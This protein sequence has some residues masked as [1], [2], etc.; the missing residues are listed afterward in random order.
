MIKKLILAM[1]LI[2]PFSMA[3][4]QE[5]NT[6]IYVLNIGK[7]DVSSG[8]YTV[9]FYLTMKCVSNCSE[10]SEF[11]NGRAT[12][13][14]KQYDDGTEKSYR[15]QASLSQNIYMRSYPFDSHRLSI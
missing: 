15:I 9:D 5:I 1:I 7:F 12:S 13:F 14:D 10:R 8:S 4:I 3:E 6:S 2:S 11:M